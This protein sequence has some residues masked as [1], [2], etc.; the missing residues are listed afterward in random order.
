[1]STKTDAYANA[2]LDST[3]GSGT[4][5]GFFVGALTAITSGAAGTVT[6]ATG[7]A[8]ARQAISFGAAAARSKANNAVI[9]LPVS[10]SDHG[11]IV[12][13]GIYSA[14]SGGSPLHVIPLGTPITYNTGYQPTIGVGVLAITEGA[15][16]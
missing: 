1:M 3:Y 2:H 11:N 13:W 15:Y 10:T 14:V 16:A 6:E 5:G 12:G 8:Y 9:S 7:G 4:A